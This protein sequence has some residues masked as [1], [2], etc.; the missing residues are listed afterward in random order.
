[1]AGT[2]RRR[3]RILDTTLRDGDQ[4]AGFAFAPEE[5]RAIARALVEAGL[6]TVETGFPLSSP[7]DF[8]TCRELA[9]E[10]PGRT[11]VM[12]RGRREDIAA[13]AKVFAGGIPGLLHISLPV[14]GIHIRAKL[15]ISGGELLG[16][17]AELAAY[18]AGLAAD[19]EM[20]AEDAT[21]CGRNF[22]LDYC[23]AVFA[24]GVKT[25]NIADT[26]G[27]SAPGEFGPLI[28]LLKRAFPEG[29]ISVHCHNDF[30]LALANTLAA[31][32]AGCDQAEVSV[33]G[34]GERAGNAALEE[35]CLNL[36]ARGATL[37]VETGLRPDHL[38]PLMALI[39]SSS[40]IDGPLKPVSGWNIRSHASG[41]HQQGLARRTETYAN[42]A[43]DTINPGPE[44]I[45]LSRHS[46]KEGLRLFARRYCGL[47][48][49]EAAVR[50]ALDR[51]KAAPGPLTGLT[52]FLC[53]LADCGFPL[54]KRP[55][56]CRSLAETL[57]TPTE[58]GPSRYTISAALGTH[59]PG[60]GDLS[61]QGAGE[62]REAAV[63]EALAGLD[64]LYGL[65]GGGIEI[66]RI[67]LTGSG[68]R[69]RVYTELTS[70]GRPFAVERRGDSAPLLLFQCCLDAVNACLQLL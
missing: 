15:G 28:T 51:V 27:L 63:L 38:P 34:A 1:M 58:T 56:V 2:P 14:S 26:L 68:A 33:G 22:L 8:E 19:V 43:L 42:H 70:G 6:D 17:A 30:G 23:G 62:S 44:R 12:C 35:L 29:R 5:K 4:A 7:A 39:R 48:L 53:I 25:V 52:E 61:V 49:G 69:L 50:E 31:V 32:E 57:E 65:G 66:T 47:E 3:L 37:A 13:T 10:F 41:I 9:R 11:A 54:K 16:R 59:P 18:A 55:L 46:G 60:S 40:A 36:E 21:R 45:I 67:G 64:G 24:A 20:G